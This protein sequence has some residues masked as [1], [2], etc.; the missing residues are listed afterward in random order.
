MSVQSR[1]L[2]ALRSH[3]HTWLYTAQ[4]RPLQQRMLD[5]GRS[6]AAEEVVVNSVTSTPP[7]RT[8]LQFGGV[9]LRARAHYNLARSKKFFAY[10]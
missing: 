10:R 5:D 9:R 1:G 7:A 4:V 8:E 6:I 2:R 3:L